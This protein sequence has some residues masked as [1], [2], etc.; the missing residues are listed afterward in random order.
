MSAD[1]FR[2]N[3]GFF[4]GRITSFRD[5]KLTEKG[6]RHLVVNVTRKFADGGVTTLPCQVHGAPVVEAVEKAFK[7]GDQVSVVYFLR[8]GHRPGVGVMVY[9]NVTAIRHLGKGASSFL[10]YGTPATEGYRQRH[11][12]YDDP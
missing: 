7:V 10:M 3:E 12:G 1:S 8:T 2:L 11:V 6:E 9:V 4:E 5:R